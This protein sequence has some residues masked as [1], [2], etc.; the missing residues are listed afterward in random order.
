MILEVN[1][2]FDERRMYFLKGSAVRDLHDAPSMDL[3]Y[4]PNGSQSDQTREP[5]PVQDITSGSAKFKTTWTKDFHVS[6]FNSRKGA[7]A[8]VAHDPL[9]PRMEGKGPVDNVITLSS[10]KKHVKLV[11]RVFSTQQAMQPSKL[12]LPHLAR[13]LLSWW[14]VGLFTFLR[15][16]KEAGKLF[17]Q[18]KLHVW[19]RPEVLQDSIGRRE[20]SE[21]RYGRIHPDLNPFYGTWLTY[22]RLLEERF[23]YFLR[24]QVEQSDIGRPVKY[25]AAGTDCQREEV[26]L[27]A[28]SQA[29]TNPA[30]DL[31]VIT[32][33]VLTPA[34]YARF[35]Q[36]AHPSELIDN[37][38]L[39][40]EEKNR[41]FWISSLEPTSRLFGKPQNT[42][43][44]KEPFAYLTGLDRARWRFLKSL[45][46]SP[47]RQSQG[48]LSKP[49]VQRTARATDIRMMP[50]SPLDNFVLGHCT[51]AD[52][53]QYRRIVTKLLVSTHIAFGYPD[54]LDLGDLLFRLL[55]CSLMIYGIGGTLEWSPPVAVALE[56][57]LSSNFSELAVLAC[58]SNSLH[59]WALVKAFL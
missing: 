57:R 50:L 29:L 25:I 19:Y 42:E 21:E 48:E 59:I 35:V 23:R 56:S 55:L 17:F 18:R 32:F 43:S 27:P 13:F 6:P 26:F 40:G 10:S 24:Y 22:H 46:T 54:I 53:W 41:T 15:I 12:T 5:F 30:G 28:N 45:R 1:N 47:K 8:L 52:V 33:K 20:T 36:Y 3:N 34:F 39:A 58:Y 37:E 2:T 38:L 9:F 14:W 7:Y 31:E 4:A 49:G 44:V 16:V 51:S 11:A